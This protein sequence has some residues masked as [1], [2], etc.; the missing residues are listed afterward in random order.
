MEAKSNQLREQMAKLEQE[1]SD[2]ERHLKTEGEEQEH[3]AADAQNRLSDLKSDILRLTTQLGEVEQD[4]ERYLEKAA[5]LE[6]RL[7][8]LTATHQESTRTLE[9]ITA[10][11]ERA[12]S[13]TRDQLQDLQS[14]NQ[15]LQDQIGDLR[16]D[17]ERLLAKT[18][19]L[20]QQMGRLKAA[21]QKST[22]AIEQLQAE[23]EQ[24]ESDAR[25]RMPSLQSHNQQLQ[26]QRGGIE[27]HRTR[28]HQ[29]GDT[30]E[31]RLEQQAAEPAAAD[32]RPEQTESD[33]KRLAS[34]RVAEDKKLEDQIRGD[35]QQHVRPEREYDAAG[36][37][38]PL[39]AQERVS[40]QET[41]DR[42]MAE[43]EQVASEL[44]GQIPD[45]T[46]YRRPR[47]TRL[48]EP[49][50]PPLDPPASTWRQGQARVS[51]QPDTRTEPAPR[52]LPS[53]QPV[54]RPRRSRRLTRPLKESYR[55]TGA[56]TTPDDRPHQ[57][58]GHRHLPHEQQRERAKLRPPETAERGLPMKGRSPQLS[59]VTKWRK[60]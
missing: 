2:R 56:V 42:R 55:S 40:L 19:D 53:C 28:V 10:G 59:T 47:P 1:L 46:A 18:S 37:D 25:H 13:E 33:L 43:H 58:S 22:D 20:G 60:T 17:R 41:L 21:N 30:R 12:E 16:Q 4:R 5:D 24:A 31:R 15:Q 14:Q 44:R 57:D 35:E 3:A 38:H 54:Q 45:L 9:Q 6:Q 8:I 26:E 29:N 39:Q 7:G 23:Q 11:H 27:P 32:D 50:R 51:V 48:A 49:H 36:H 52:D 34:E